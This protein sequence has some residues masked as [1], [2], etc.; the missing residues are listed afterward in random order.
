MS[1]TP[2][3]PFDRATVEAIA[4]ILGETN[5]GLTNA[6]IEKILAAGNIS[7]PVAEARAANPLVAQGLAYV[8]LS[9]RDRIARAIINHQVKRQNGNALV[10]FI[11]DAMKPALYVND[12]ARHRWYQ[13][14]LN[15][16]LIL[17]GLRV[18][19]KGQVSTARQAAATLS[20]AALLAGT[21]MTELGRRQA[22]DQVFAYCTEEI[23]AKDAFHAVHEAVKGICQR[24]RDSTGSDADGH[25]L[26]DLALGRSRES[27]PVLRLNTLAS[28]SDWNEQNGLATLI[29]GL[30]TRYRNPTAHQARVLRDAERPILERELLEVLTTI[31]LVHHALDSA[32]LG[33]S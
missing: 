11:T 17:E 5:Q 28:E 20:E 26:I 16:V 3:P 13:S 24:L 25:T 10:R 9:K 18:N 6:Q 8:S 12:P 23:I 21:L 31:S 22:H 14:R 30:W 19:D 15:E 32:T 27:E 33:D 1:K 2:I 7:D 29:K 4:A